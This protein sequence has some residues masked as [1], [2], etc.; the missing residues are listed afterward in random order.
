MLRGLTQPKRPWDTKSRARRNS[1]RPNQ[2]ARPMSEGADASGPPA[3]VGQ[4]RTALRDATPCDVQRALVPDTFCPYQKHAVEFALSR[5]G[6]VL[7]G[8]E[9]GLGKTAM[10]LSIVAHFLPADGPALIIAP[11]VLL[12]Q[13]RSEI[14]LWVPGATRSD[15]QVV[16]K[17]S[18]RP[19]P[20][21]RFVLVSYA[22]AT[23]VRDK[24]THAQTNG[25]LRVAADGADWRIVVADEAHL[26][27][28]P[29]SSRTRTL[30]PLLQ[31]ARRAVLMTGTPMANSCAADLHPLLSAV[32]GPRALPPFGAWCR[33]YCREN[34]Q[35]YTGFRYID[36]WVGVSEEN[37]AELREILGIAM[38]RKRKDQ[39]LDQLPPKRRNKVALQLKPSELKRVAAQMKKIE[40]L[41]KAAGGADGDDLPA[42]EL[43]RVFQ[44]L[45]DAK[46]NA[47]KEW[48]EASL[49]EGDFGSERKAVR[50]PL[51]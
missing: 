20:S 2:R 32:G 43:M 7:L 49:L 22:M 24:H 27:K 44:L 28:S 36:R 42:H 39:V 38:V 14:L 5:G 47:V 12:E 31:K 37:E 48:L 45:A 8:H 21:A 30:L 6:R 17:G 10:A 26:L 9:M 23:G 51:R 19:D 29:D 25:Q 40:D 15:V 11:P 46:C 4:A 41:Q 18:D 35:I 3:W 50:S 1:A 13:W 33:R 16:R 34:A